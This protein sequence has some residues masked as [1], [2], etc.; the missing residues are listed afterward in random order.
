MSNQILDSITNNQGTG[1][2]GA[3][4]SVMNQAQ[5]MYQ[6]CMTSAN[7][8]ETFNNMVSSNPNYHTAMDLVNQ[9]GGD[10]KKAFFTA[11]MSRGLMNR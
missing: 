1:T 5:Q 9:C 3:P 2:G 4:A 6:Q 7:P 8:Q 10:P 11:L